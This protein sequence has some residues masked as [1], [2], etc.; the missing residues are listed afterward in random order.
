M[1]NILQ[2]LLFDSNLTQEK[3]AESVGIKI[4]T[5]QYQLKKKHTFNLS[6]EYAQKLGINKIKGYE[7]GCYIEFEIK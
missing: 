7:C 3:F 4:K 1:R 6:L 2:T 5:L